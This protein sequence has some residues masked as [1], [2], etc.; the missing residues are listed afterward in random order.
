MAQKKPYNPNTPYGRK[1]L[2][3]AAA[4]SYNNMSPQEKK[5]HDSSKFW[6]MLII[7]IIVGGLIFLIGGSGALTKWLSR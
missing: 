6:I 4:Q 2:R 7:L 3:E 5:V 1:K